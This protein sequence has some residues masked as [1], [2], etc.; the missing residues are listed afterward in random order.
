MR[1][2][3]LDGRL[4][5]LTGSGALDVADA[6]GGLFGADPQAVYPRW[7]EFVSWAATAS[8]GAPYD[9]ARLGPPV[10]APR[11]VFAIGMNYHAHAA[12]SGFETPDRPTVFTK[13]PSCVTG[14]RGSIPLPPGGDTDWEVEL[15]VVIGATAREVKAED[16]WNHVA[17]LTAGQD[18]SERIGQLAGPAPQFSLG[19]SHP[20]FGPIGPCL[21]TPDEFDDA[22][23]I[24]VSCYVNGERVQSGRTGDLVFPVAALIAE[25]SATLPLLPGDLI[26][27]GTPEGV[28]LGR[29]PPRYLAP[30]DELV[31]GVAGVGEMRHRLI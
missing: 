18:L 21:V 12:E 15:V 25:L 24:E 8:G 30:G 9:P 5:L 27:T 26:F 4:V 1:I 3:N 29:T 14:P 20:G 31:T 10:P 2:A 19:K 16:A 23:D 22:D 11:Q 28:G 13:F 7:A 6:S 17:G